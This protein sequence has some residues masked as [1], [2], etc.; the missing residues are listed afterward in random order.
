MKPRATRWIISGLVAVAT[1][2]LSVLPAPAATGGSPKDTAKWRLATL[3][4][5]RD[6]LDQ[7]E[8]PAPP[9]PSERV[10]LAERLNEAMRQDVAAHSSRDE[11]LRRCT[12]ATAQY[13][14]EILDKRFKAILARATEQS[15]Q[16]VTWPD[17]APHLGGNWNQKLD[18]A[19]AAF[20]NTEAGL[21][22][23][24]A[25]ARAIGLLRQELEQG[26]RFPTEAEANA[27]LAERIATHPDSLRWRSGDEA[28]LQEKI[29]QLLNPGRRPLFEELKSPLAERTRRIATE[30]RRQY[31]RQMDL[32]DEA[33]R[34]LPDNRREASTIA[35][36]LETDLAN[37]LSSE[38]AK[39]IPVDES[40]MAPP[41]YGLFSP[42]RESLPKLATELETGRL[43][44]YLEQTPELSLRA[45]DLAATIAKTPEKHRT[46]PES[47]AALTGELAQPLLQTAIGSYAA[48]ADPSGHEAYFRALAEQDPVVSGAFRTRLNDELKRQLP[49]ARRV[50]SAAQYERRFSDLDPNSPLP[51][52]ALAHLQDTGGAAATNLTEALKL[53]G[54]TTRAGDTLLEETV[55]KVI[56]LANR[57]AREGY[58]VVTGQATLLKQWEAE[59][60]ETLRQDVVLHRSVKEIRAEWEKGLDTGWQSDTRS[61][62]TPYHRL[63]EL[64]LANLNKTVRQ[65]Y[66]TLQDNPQ[67]ALTSPTVVAQ[68]GS[69][70]DDGKRKEA[71][72]EPAKPEEKNPEPKQDDPKPQEPQPKQDDKPPEEKVSE[73]DPQ[74][75]QATPEAVMARLKADRRNAPDGV[76]LL[77]E[78]GDGKTMARLITLSEA[79]SQ[80]VTFFAGKPQD[81]AT[82]LFEAMKP[83]LEGLWK[84]TVGN[85]QDAHSG[86]G[87]LKRK[88]PP[89]MKLLIVVQS[90][91][92]RH[93]MNLLLRDRIEE[94]FA[95]WQS[96]Q[97][98]T[99]PP[100][101]LDWKVGLTFEPDTKG[102]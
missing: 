28:P 26:L 11:S 72:Q 75:T 78:V 16:P 27:L 67:A 18:K 3:A 93:R 62:S 48:S 43:R 52:D 53:F 35:S 20:A 73:P 50:V 81:A 38:R 95:E 79:E 64:T 14:R 13:Q 65:L 42:I 70:Q 33:A 47:E 1:G 10:L 58:D 61:Q 101:E 29:L 36:Q 86:L 71:R 45:A 66:D 32:R 60:L 5:A 54:R 99:T 8:H 19:V 21:S 25:R 87:F 39:P 77:T 2:G 84:N 55:Q 97:G 74:Q 40:G 51:D 76:L 90:D 98:G 31:E 80:D 7:V 91:D 56:D 34:G 49:E 83:A 100:V 12:G 69:E 102:Q 85:W 37:G 9:L 68:A 96:R 23:K 63:L 59:H 92:V 22:F 82:S 57:K 88:T 24:E 41:S 89:R 15:P 17:V 46:L 30:L 94:A 44:R 4:A 6:I